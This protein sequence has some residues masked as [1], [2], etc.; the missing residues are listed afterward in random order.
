MQTRA[1]KH[2]HQ[3]RD[4]KEDVESLFGVGFFFEKK[5]IGKGSGF[6]CEVLGG[7]KGWSKRAKKEGEGARERG[8]RGERG[9]I[10]TSNLAKIP[11]GHHHKP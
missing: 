5:K 4:P 11:N 10:V 2:A 8:E 6:L 9:G 3:G 1:R 7:G